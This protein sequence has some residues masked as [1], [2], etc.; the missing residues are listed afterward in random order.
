MVRGKDKELGLKRHPI[1][2]GSTSKNYPDDFI[3][4][5]TSWK[6]P[7][8][9]LYETFCP[10]RL[11]KKLRI[12]TILEDLDLGSIQFPVQTAMSYICKDV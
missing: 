2:S 5:V 12:R 11:Q 3:L 1:N 6:I 4:A 8:C 7:A 10:C 9:R